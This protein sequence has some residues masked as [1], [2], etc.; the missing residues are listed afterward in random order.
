[1]LEVLIDVE[2]APCRFSIPAHP[3]LWIL[4]KRRASPWRMPR[5][6]QPPSIRPSHCSSTTRHRASP[7]PT[8]AWIYCHKLSCARV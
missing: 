1:M 2:A 4:S 8:I 7:S 3:V 6:S 5:Q